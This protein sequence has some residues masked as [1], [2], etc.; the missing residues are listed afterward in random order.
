MV[1]TLNNTDL[2]DENTPGHGFGGGEGN[3]FLAEARRQ[4]HEARFSKPDV[5]VEDAGGSQMKALGIPRVP[6]DGPRPQVVRRSQQRFGT[7]SRT[8]SSTR[9]S[10]S[11]RHSSELAFQAQDLLNSRD[12]AGGTVAYLQSCGYSERLSA[13][14]WAVAG[15]PARSRGPVGQTKRTS[16]RSASGVS[17]Q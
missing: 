12:I 3:A 15:A 17:R 6:E 11:N 13:H 2:G 9:T 5:A 16:M 10:N 14:A 7:A 1:I 8:R 4:R